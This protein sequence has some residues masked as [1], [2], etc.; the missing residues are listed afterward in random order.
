VID[1]CPSA[2][3]GQIGAIEEGGFDAHRKPEANGDQIESGFAFGGNGKGGARH[4]PTISRRVEVNDQRIV[5]NDPAPIC[6]LVNLSP[7]LD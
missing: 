7:D 5:R 4:Q 3:V 6:C 1:R 2:K